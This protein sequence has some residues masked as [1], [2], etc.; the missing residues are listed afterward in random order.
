MSDHLIEFFQPGPGIGPG[1]R[2]QGIKGEGRNVSAD[3]VD[4][5]IGESRQREQVTVVSFPVK[6]YEGLALAFE[7]VEDQEP[8]IGF[9]S[10][11]STEDGQMLDPFIFS[12]AKGIKFLTGIV[13]SPYGVFTGGSFP[14]WRQKGRLSVFQTG[15]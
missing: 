5:D 6:Q 9:T 15:W 3:G 2:D 7:L 1:R 12:Q 10:S 13:D 4:L 14:G 11:A 8:Q